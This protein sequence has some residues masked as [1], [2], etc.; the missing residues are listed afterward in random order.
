MTI[1]AGKLRDS[2]D[3]SVCMNLRVWVRYKI[4]I[5]YMHLLQHA[6]QYLVAPE[7]ALRQQYLRCL[8]ALGLLLLYKDA[9]HTTTVKRA[10]SKVTRKLI[11]CNVLVW[12]DQNSTA[13]F[14]LFATAV[15]YAVT[16][17]NQNKASRLTPFWRHCRRG[18]TVYIF[19]HPRYHKEHHE[20]DAVQDFH[21]SRIL[22]LMICER[23]VPSVVAKKH[24]RRRRP[25]ITC[26]ARKNYRQKMEIVLWI[27][28]VFKSSGI[29]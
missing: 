4:L 23:P 7:H 11:P 5:T 9:R 15:I 24:S 28:S 29:L 18:W 26:F 2:I 12:L 6:E 8:D 25:V 19:E 22:S 20:Y 17:Q 14:F 27:S 3:I 21:T 16:W 1:S 10:A 13:E